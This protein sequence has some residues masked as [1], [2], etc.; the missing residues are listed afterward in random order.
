MDGKRINKTAFCKC[1]N[2]N[3]GVC[4]LLL[5]LLDSGEFCDLN[6]DVSKRALLDKVLPLI[7]QQYIEQWL[8]DVNRDGSRTGNGANKPRIYK[9]FKHNFQPE[10]DC[11]SYSSG[12]F[13]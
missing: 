4:K 11:K 7:S 13:I 5:E 10:N 9:S 6:R 2:W 1:K 8:N 3:F 12:H